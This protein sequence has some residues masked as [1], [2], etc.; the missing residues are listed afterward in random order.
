MWRA[1]LIETMSGLKGPEVEMSTNG[2]YDIILNQAG[3]ATV[4]VQKSSLDGITKR[5]LRPWAHGFVLTLESEAMGEVP[6]FAGP[7]TAPPDEYV[8]SLSFSVSGIRSIFEHRFLLKEDYTPA[9]LPAPTQT[10][11][12]HN[13]RSRA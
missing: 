6:V 8:D 13:D 5:W 9:T 2:R 10:L 4:T 11:R 7:I 12:T 1:Y 3:A